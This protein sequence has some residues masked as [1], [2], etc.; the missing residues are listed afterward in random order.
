MIAC[1][2]WSRRVATT[3]ILCREWCEARRYLLMLTACHRS[4]EGYRS[5]W[6]ALQERAW[7]LP[8]SATLTLWRGFITLHGTVLVSTVSVPG[9]NIEFGH[10]DAP[11]L[12]LVATVMRLGVRS[13]R[14]HGRRISSVASKGGGSSRALMPDSRKNV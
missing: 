1:R 4:V 3:L 5:G 2:P 11:L 14:R 13:S 8:A 7:H 6:C 10:L 9:G 12:A